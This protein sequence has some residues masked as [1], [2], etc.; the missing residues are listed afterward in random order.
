VRVYVGDTSRVMCGV[1]GRV[2]SEMTAAVQRDKNVLLV[3][4]VGR[5]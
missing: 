5:K 2:L 1:I 4:G 3:S